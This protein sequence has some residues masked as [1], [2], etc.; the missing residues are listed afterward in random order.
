[1]TEDSTTDRI[2][3]LIDATREYFRATPE[4]RAAGTIGAWLFRLQA[5]G[6]PQTVEELAVVT[7]RPAHEVTEMLT[8]TLGMR[9]DG[10]GHVLDDP[11]ATLPRYRVRMLDTGHETQVQG[12]AVDALLLPAL[13]GRP[14]RINATCPITRQRVRIDVA[15]DGSGNAQPSGVMVSLVVP[16]CETTDLRSSVCMH[17]HVFASA[18]AASD[19]HAQHPKAAVVSVAGALRY[20]A[21]AAQEFPATSEHHSSR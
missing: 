7:G 1:M 11:D 20:A 16:G 10:D 13:T 17:G 4:F 15:H 18:E 3:E 9:V 2:D 8:N 6:R 21:A 19:W 12:C 14:A 5:E